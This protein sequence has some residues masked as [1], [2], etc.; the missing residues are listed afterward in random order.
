MPEI[1]VV[2][3]M[4]LIGFLF[5]RFLKHREI[6]NEMDSRNRRNNDPK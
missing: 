2:G 6:K 4:I 3:A 1:I 5:H